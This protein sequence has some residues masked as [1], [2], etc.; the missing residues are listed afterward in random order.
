MCEAI[1]RTTKILPRPGRCPGGR[2][3]HLH[4]RRPLAARDPPQSSKTRP[5][6][7]PPPPQVQPPHLL[8]EPHTGQ[9]SDPS[10]TE[11][12]P[13]LPL[14]CRAGACLGSHR[15]SALPL[16]CSACAADPSSP[17]GPPLPPP[18]DAHCPGCQALRLPS[19]WDL[20]TNGVSSGFQAER[21]SG[22]WTLGRG[23]CSDPRGGTRLGGGPTTPFPGRQGLPSPDGHLQREGPFSSGLWPQR[24]PRH[25]SGAV[26]AG[27]KPAFFARCPGNA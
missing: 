2:P 1:T 25:C 3:L 24:P 7:A 18:A 10:T 22:H 8:Q 14:V 20:Q 5:P 23:I 4:T 11:A 27:T 16:V 6:R 19:C 17:A 26:R 13:Q 21:V 9:G 12:G 15:R